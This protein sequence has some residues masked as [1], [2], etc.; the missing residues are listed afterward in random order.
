MIISAFHVVIAGSAGNIL[1]YT[2]KVLWVAILPSIIYSSSGTR[3]VSYTDHSS[4]H[5]IQHPAGLILLSSQLRL[6][7]S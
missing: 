3:E 4:L 7:S 6:V 1:L 2:I 5:G